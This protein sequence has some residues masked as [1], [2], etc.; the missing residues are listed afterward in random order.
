[1]F[2]ARN[3]PNPLKELSRPADNRTKSAMSQTLQ[4]PFLEIE[5]SFPEVLYVLKHPPSG[6]FGCYCHLGVHG[7]ACFSSEAGA[8]RFG[9]WIDLCGMSC[10]EVTFEEARDIA[11]ARPMPIISL[12]LLDNL[13]DPQIHYIR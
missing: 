11:K 9:E 1:M 12:M 13:V 6:K 8:F 7:L 4:C 2:Q 5:D 3:G 10:I